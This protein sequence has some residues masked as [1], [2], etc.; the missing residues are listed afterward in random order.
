MKYKLITSL[1][2]LL[3]LAAVVCGQKKAAA[4]PNEF[5][6][7]LQDGLRPWQTRKLYSRPL[8]E[9][10]ATLQ[11]K[12]GVFDPVLGRSLRG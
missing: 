11:V 3:L 8:D 9:A 4:D 1:V 6:D 10:P 5:P 7:Q 2:L 12:T